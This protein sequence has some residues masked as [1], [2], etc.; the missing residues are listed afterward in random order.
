MMQHMFFGTMNTMLDI[1]GALKNR[2]LCANREEFE[3]EWLGVAPR[4]TLVYGAPSLPANLRLYVRLLNCGPGQA[5]LATT[6]WKR[7]LSQLEVPRQPRTN[8]KTMHR[9]KPQIFARHKVK[10]TNE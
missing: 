2:K 1:L 6:V 10:E 4:Y 7:M 5:D 8:A 3:T 9:R